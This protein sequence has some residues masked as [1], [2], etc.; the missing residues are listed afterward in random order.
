MLPG[1]EAAAAGGEV[2]Q[3]VHRAAQLSDRAGAA[4]LEALAREPVDPAP[5]RQRLE[6]HPAARVVLEHRRAEVR[7]LAGGRHRRARP[8]AGV[9]AEDQERGLEPARGE[10]MLGGERVDRAEDGRELGRPQAFEALDGAMGIFVVAQVAGVGGGA[11]A[12]GQERVAECAR[13]RGRIAGAADRGLQPRLGGGLSA[14]HRGLELPGPLGL[15]DL[16]LRRR[17]RARLADRAAAAQPG[18]EQQYRDPSPGHGTGSSIRRAQLTRSVRIPT[19]QAGVA[20]PAKANR[21]MPGLTK[22][23]CGWVRER[24]CRP[25]WPARGVDPGNRP[26][27]KESGSPP[28]IGTPWAGRHRRTSLRPTRRALVFRARS[29]VRSA[30]TMRGCTK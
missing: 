16:R 26:P 25:G 13:D 8:E 23:N 1:R 22:V 15:E 30:A 7:A 6:L 18:H 28:R 2:E 20:T 17:P 14:P 10:Q 11:D 27:G 3:A 19:D 21:V 5:A 24:G 12:L 9:A 4:V 29:C